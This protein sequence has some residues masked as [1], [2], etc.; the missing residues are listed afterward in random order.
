[1]TAQEIKQIYSMRDILARYGL[2][3]NRAGFIR[4][5][6][7]NGDNTASMKIYQNDFH[8]YGC[9]ANGDIFKFVML[10]DRLSF[11]DAFLSLGGTYDHPE[12]AR[13][14]RK[15]KKKLLI[16]AQDRERSRRILERKKQEMRKLTEVANTYR[17]VLKGWKPFTPEWCECMNGYLSA[18]YDSELLWEEVS[19]K[20]NGS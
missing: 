13:E 5:P 9:G 16:L 7:H 14:R 2:K 11:K 4:C 6:F 19:G 18:L 17:V 3:P 15:R 10:M 8:C 20:N 1:M 12:S